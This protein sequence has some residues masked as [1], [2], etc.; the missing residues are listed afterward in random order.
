MTALKTG[1]VIFAITAAI[2]AY[3]IG[4]APAGIEI[5][6]H[7]GIDGSP[8]RMGSVTEGMLMPP[9]VMLLILAVMSALKWFEPRKENL[10]RSNTARGWIALSVILLM[11]VIEVGNIAILNGYEAPMVR[12]VFFG[13]GLMLMVMGNFFSKVRSNFFIGIRTPWTLSSD[14]VWQKTHRLGG[15]LFMLAGALLVPAAWGLAESALIYAMA[16]LIVPAVLIPAFYSWWLWK[17]E[18]S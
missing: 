11:M 14:Q 15:K 9:A 10:L 8:D 7:W 18:Q 1:W 17:K 3:Y 12:L 2:S 16:A 13:V 6:I 4:T 5:P